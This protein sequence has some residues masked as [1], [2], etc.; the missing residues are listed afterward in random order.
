M[1]ERIPY[2]APLQQK[3]HGGDTV[4]MANGAKVIS[5]HK[6]RLK[7]SMG[8]FRTR[9]AFHVLPELE[10]DMVLGMS[11]I[12]ELNPSIDWKQLS[13]TVVRRPCT[14]CPTHAPGAG[15]AGRVLQQAPT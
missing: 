15:A 3:H 5:T 2:K 9:A 6:T 1:R 13:M 7:F 4:R 10:Y 14:G 8:K 12:R 11:F